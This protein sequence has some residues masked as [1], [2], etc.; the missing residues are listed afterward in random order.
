MCRKRAR[1]SSE[2]RYKA[3]FEN[4]AEMEELDRLAE[5]KESSKGELR[6]IFQVD[7]RAWLPE[8]YEKRSGVVASA[9]GAGAGA[10]EGELAAH[11]IDSSDSESEYVMRS[12]RERQEYNARLRWKLDS[13]ALLDDF[14]MR[15]ER[16]RGALGL[17]IAAPPSVSSSATEVEQAQGQQESAEAENEIEVAAARQLTPMEEAEQPAVDVAQEADQR[18]RQI[19]LERRGLLAAV[20]HKAC[21]L[22]GSLVKSCVTAVADNVVD[23]DGRKRE[24]AIQAYER[25]TNIMY[26]RF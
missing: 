4:E 6:K 2:R 17:A 18:E 10:G 14:V 7:L 21:W 25:M 15:E 1:R 23:R 12:V 19:E 3:G 22:L 9:A 8:Y 20:W 26:L 5:L 11:E 13:E 24:A 16:R